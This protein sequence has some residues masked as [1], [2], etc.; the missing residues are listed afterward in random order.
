MHGK[1]GS[2]SEAKVDGDK[3]TAEAE[4]GEPT[5]RRA[6]NL[7]AS[8][9]LVKKKL[10]SLSETSLLARREKVHVISKGSSASLSADFSAKA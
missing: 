4:T 2:P 7:K 1:R 9:T 5:V 10:P 6:A 8:K 3:V